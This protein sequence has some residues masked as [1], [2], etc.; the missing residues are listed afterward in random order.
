MK[1]DIWIT[2]IAMSTLLFNLC[3]AKQGSTAHIRDRV[4]IEYSI[5][6]PVVMLR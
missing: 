2:R 5:I 1:E 4:T 6:L 3:S